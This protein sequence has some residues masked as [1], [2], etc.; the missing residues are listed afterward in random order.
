MDVHSAHAGALVHTHT[1]TYTR[2][3]THTIVNGNHIFTHTLT[4]IYALAAFILSLFLS[5]T[6]T[7]HPNRVGGGGIE[8]SMTL[9]SISVFPKWW[10]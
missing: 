6:H 8:R 4:N 5:L 9:I 1:H 3:Y 2:I 7:H 10:K